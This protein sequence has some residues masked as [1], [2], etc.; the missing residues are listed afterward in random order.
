MNYYEVA[1]TKIVRLGA[2]TFTY[3]SEAPLA[4]GQLVLIEVGKKQ[5]SGMVVKQVAQ[6]DYA[7]KPIVSLID[8]TP[9]PKALVDTALWLS[10]YYLTPLALVLQAVLPTGLTKNRRAVATPAAL[11]VRDRTKIVF[12]ADQE[13]ALKVLSGGEG[14]YIL[15]GVT[16][17]GK[18]ELYKELTRRA[19]TEGKSAIILTPEIGLTPQLVAE[20]TH[21]FPGLLLTHSQQTEAERHRTWL[22]ALHST[23]PRVVIGPRSAL[24][25]PLKNVGLIVIDEAHE[26]SYKQEQ[27]PRYSALRV[28]TMLGRFHHATVVFGSATPS[29]AD[30]YVAEE[31]GRPIAF[32]K[33]RARQNATPPEV[34]VIDNKTRSNFKRHRFLSDP[35]LLA[36]EQNLA[37]NRQTL[38]FH[39]RRG[40]AATTLCENCGWTA[41]CPNCFVPLTLHTDHYQ[42]MCHL[43][44]H[45]EK[46]PTVCPVCQ[47]ADIIHKGIG[48]KLIESELKRVFPKAAVARFDSDSTGDQTIAAQYQALYDGKIDIAIG[49]QMVAKG[50]DLPHLGSVGVI[51]ADSG[52]ALPD[53]ASEERTFQL[54]SQVIGRVGRTEHPTSV[55]IQTYQPTHAAIV[56]GIAQDYETF[57]E[58]TLEVRKAGLFPPFVFLLKL[59]CV[60]KTEAAAIRNAQ[61]LARTLRKQFPGVQVLGPTPAFYERVGDTYRWQLVLKSKKREQLVEALALVPTTHWQAELDPT[62]LL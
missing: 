47:H 11:P 34:T 28:A 26:P 59:V 23:E 27:A 57:Y 56:N 5:L 46:V 21:D 16:G 44:G 14:T 17:S 38:I 37:S 24:F 62:S 61:E 35:L 55:F 18:T 33:E 42:L 41:L 36:I 58:H 8:E 1:P 50:L 32:M 49:T 54:L 22:E 15:Q 43:C 31:T 29:V 30:R 6:P 45:H 13:A 48:T 19:I 60:Y 20:F 12:N 3:A 2:D 9:V 39:N 53:Y 52:L 40:S 25:L 4:V 10:Q 7:T 51:Q